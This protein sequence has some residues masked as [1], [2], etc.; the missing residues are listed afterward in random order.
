MHIIPVVESLCLEESNEFYSFVLNSLFEM[1][2]LQSKQSV[3]LIFG[4]CRITK[5]LL[6]LIGIEQ[7]KDC[8]VI[9][10]SFHLTSQVWPQEFGPALV[11]IVRRWYMPKLKQRWMKHSRQLNGNWEGSPAR[12]ITC[13]DFMS[14]TRALLSVMLRQSHTI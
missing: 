1:E 8:W 10:D 2:P 3:Q 4:D 14:I 12:L 7:G 5:T 6:P 11:M 9:W 13:N